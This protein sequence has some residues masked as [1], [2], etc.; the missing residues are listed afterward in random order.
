MEQRPLDSSTLEICKSSSGIAREMEQRPLDSSTLEICKSSSGTAREMEQRPL[1]S[2]TLEIYISSSGIAR[3]KK[4][5]SIKLLN[6]TF[7]TPPYSDYGYMRADGFSGPCVRDPAVNLAS[8]CLKDNTTS[9]MKSSGYRKIPGDVCTD[10]VSGE[11]NPQLVPCCESPTNTPPPTG[12][13]DKT[14]SSM[15]TSGGSTAPI[16]GGSL[17]GTTGS[18]F[19][20]ELFLGAMY[21]CECL[22]SPP[23]Q[24]QSRDSSGSRSAVCSGSAGGHCVRHRFGHLHVVKLPSPPLPPLPSPPLPSPPLPSPP[25][26]QR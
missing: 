4:Q 22:P 10:G 3:K 14:P 16:T 1:D 25:L 20:S 9:Y 17:S 8:P 5:R 21:T 15:A 2:S 6:T 11:F 7:L 26:P 13:S 23:R 12:S 19:S 18:Q 24:R